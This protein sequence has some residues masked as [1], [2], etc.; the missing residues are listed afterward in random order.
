VDELL[1]DPKRLER[2]GQAMSALARP[3][4]ADCIAEEL[5]RLAS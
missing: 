1:S 4:A 5:I 3:D 2:M